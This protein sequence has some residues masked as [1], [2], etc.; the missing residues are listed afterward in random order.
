MTVD[1]CDADHG[2]AQSD[3]QKLNSSTSRLHQK[4]DAAIASG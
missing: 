3:P 2:L 4:Q 1:R